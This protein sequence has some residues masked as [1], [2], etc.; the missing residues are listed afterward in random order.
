MFYYYGRK[1]R[2][3]RTYPA[4]VHGLV[5]EPFA[6]SLAYSLHHRP[7]AAMGV[8][9]DERVVE[10]WHRL[11][12]MGVDGLASA[13]APPL[14]ERTDDLWHLTAMASKDSLTVGGY[15]VS[16]WGQASWE[17]ARKVAIRHVDYAA[18][19]VEYVQGDYMDAPDVEATWFIDPP[20]QRVER[21][22]RESS[23]Q[24]DYAALAEWCRSRR[25]QVI[26]C[27]QEGADWLPF[28]PHRVQQNVQSTGRSREVVWTS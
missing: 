12:G 17:L 5:I 25:G 8:E 22:Y 2:L 27:E 21:G 9:A 1:G 11:V 19:A 28:Q 24:I 18:S 16:H 6:G 20:Y 26:V 10:L 23:R 4:P 14:G 7:N 13:S 15:T 3:A